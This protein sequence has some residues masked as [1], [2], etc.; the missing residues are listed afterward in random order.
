MNCPT[1]K[2]GKINEQ[3]C[4]KEHP[5]ICFKFCVDYGFAVFVILFLWWLLVLIKLSS[6]GPGIFSQTRVGQDEV[7]F[8]LYNFALWQVEQF[9]LAPII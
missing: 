8:T 2:R 4:E 3:N 7:A 6:K 9:K 1:L 5:I